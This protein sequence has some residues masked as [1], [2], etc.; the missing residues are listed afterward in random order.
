MPRGAESSLHAQLALLTC[1]EKP[2]GAEEVQAL[3]K[4]IQNQLA[5]MPK[6]EIYFYQ[7]VCNYFILLLGSRWT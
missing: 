4:E 3:R 2:L 1:S 5:T 6:V 7:L